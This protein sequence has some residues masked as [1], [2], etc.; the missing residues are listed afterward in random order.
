V[1]TSQDL[2]HR[3]LIERNVDMLIAW[4]WGPI[5]DERLAFEFLYDD[6]YVVVASP[7][8]RWTRRR[9]ID[10]AELVDEPWVLQPQDSVLG[11]LL[12][13]AFRSKGLDYPRAS[14]VT[15]P[16][17]V[18]TKLL[19]TGRFLTL[20]PASALK[21]ATERSNLKV[22]PVQLPPAKLP[23]GIVTL[24]IRSLSPVAQ[25]FIEHAREVAKPR[26]TRR[27]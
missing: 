13:E 23:I 26:A 4:R 8:N 6:S 3:E 20:F 24:K 1:T 19:A 17:E 18:R 14:V 22:L 10:L 21:F 15:M 16:G 2:L 5:V 25:L 12:T 9:T 7:Q 11:S 27:A